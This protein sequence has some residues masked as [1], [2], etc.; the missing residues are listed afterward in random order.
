MR[1]H[2]SMPVR[3]PDIARRQ[4]LL[5][6]AAMPQVRAALADTSI[7]ARLPP[8]WKT[9]RDPE[10]GRTLRQLTSSRANSYPL[11]YFIPSLTSDNRYLVFHSERSGWVELY[12]MDLKDGAI[13]QLTAGR[14]RD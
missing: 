3:A 6:T 5:G 10:T 9:S 1:E 11:Y 2:R 14:T 4:F 13:T 8:E 7:G 12:R